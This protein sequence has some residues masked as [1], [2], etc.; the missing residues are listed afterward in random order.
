MASA[1]LL[2]ALTVALMLL[3]GLG[4]T[5]SRRRRTFDRF[6]GGVRTLQGSDAIT[7]LGKSGLSGVC[8]ARSPRRAALSAAF[9]CCG[10]GACLWHLCGALRRDPWRPPWLCF[11]RKFVYVFERPRS[12][13]KAALSP[14]GARHGSLRSPNGT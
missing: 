3:Q 8:P 10:V 2:R 11:C 6:R 14:Q 4:C 7:N 13:R 12:G 9:V 1:R 5:P